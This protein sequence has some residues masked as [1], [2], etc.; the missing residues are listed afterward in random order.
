VQEEQ[1]QRGPVD[2]ERLQRVTRVS[3]WDA[4]TSEALLKTQLSVTT[5]GRFT[6]SFEVAELR[7][8]YI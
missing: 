2:D 6:C 8:G 5:R 3:P 7:L 4:Q 1:R